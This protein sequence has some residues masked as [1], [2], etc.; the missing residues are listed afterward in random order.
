MA[1]MKT[2][3]AA[4]AGLGGMLLPACAWAAEA[5][6]AGM[7]QLDFANRYTLTQVAWLAVIFV[8]LYILLAYGALPRVES[9]LQ[10]RAQRL[11]NDLEAARAAK[12]DS[13]AAIAEMNIAIRHAHA[14]AQSDIATAIAKAKTAAEAQAHEVNAKLAAQLAESEERIKV[15]RQGAMGALSQVASETASL[16]YT[17]LTGA[18]PDPD[19]LKSAIGTALAARPQG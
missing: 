7:P 3:L 4:L 16:V 18:T 15:A 2:P 10:N 14:N 13:D 17:R 1:R 8:V 19:L 12:A 11:S 9:V 5:E 6:Q